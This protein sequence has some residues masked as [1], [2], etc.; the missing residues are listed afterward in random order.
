MSRPATRPLPFVPAA[1]AL[2]VIAVLLA[3]VSLGQE[4]GVTSATGPAGAGA[5][6]LG[7]G[8]EAIEADELF[9]TVAAAQ[10]E[11]G[12]WEVSSV[13]Q[14]AEGDLPTATQQIDLLGDQVRFRVLMEVRGRAVEGRWV[15]EAFSALEQHGYHV[16][17]AYT[18]ARGDDAKFLYRDGLWHGADLLG[19]GVA[20][21]SHVGGVHFQNV[22]DFDPYLECVESG[23]LPIHRAMQVDDDQR[24][25]REFHRVLRPGGCLMATVPAHPYLWSDHD[26]ALHHFR[27][28]TAKS[29]RRLL[30]TG[31]LRPLRFSYCITIVHPPIVIFRLVQKT[32]QRLVY[33]PGQHRHRTHLIRLPQWANKLLIKVLR[34]EASLL[35]RID[36]PVG[37]SL[38]TLAQKK[39]PSTDSTD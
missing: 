35:R 28:Y 33:K 11:A 32:F 7:E 37:T 23:R 17:S 6:E 39:S 2:V 27:R 14:M 12:S 36:L 13:A 24:L 3:M 1:A 30:A 34:L 25:I 10:R 31:K 16:G 5:A 4:D 18:A 26:I 22:H 38:I 8:F 21:F 15:D 29:L 19:V 9:A 20:S